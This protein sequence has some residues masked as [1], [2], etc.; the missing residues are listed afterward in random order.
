MLPHK[1]LVQ[2]IFVA[3]LAFWSSRIPQAGETLIGD[4]FHM[5]CG[6]K[7]SNQAVAA[8]RSGGDVRFISLLGE[9]TFGR[10]ALDF[11]A[12]EKVDVT[13][14][15]Q[16]STV[17]TGAAAILIDQDSGQNSIVVV[18][19]AGAELNNIQ[20][21]AAISAMRP[22]DFYLTQL[23]TKLA[24]TIFGL[25]IAKRAQLQTILNPAPALELPRDIFSK[26]DICTPNEVEAA[27][28]CGFAIKNA[29]DA[30]RAADTL[31]N[32]GVKNALITMGAQGVY[33]KNQECAQWFEAHNAGKV[34]DTSGAG[35][36]FNGAL[37]AALSERKP[38]LEAVRFA[39]VAAGISVTRIGTASSAPNKAEILAEISPD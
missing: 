1:I 15:T 7:G 20:I 34:T 38:I 11:Y 31:L 14:V 36:V 10:M 32:L 12:N 24:Q 30:E 5:G 16:T 37:T 19:G 6:G 3:D 17:K 23:E 4:S 25:E 26:I 35:D 21:E 28:I 39:N 27:Q 18:P 33:F 8:K 9:D 29:T 22:G 2:G 13:Y